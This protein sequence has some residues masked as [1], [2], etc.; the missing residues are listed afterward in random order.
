MQ[1]NPDV[2]RSRLL[3][4]A[5]K[6]GLPLSIATETA[7]P[8]VRVNSD[9]DEDPIIE[10]NDP[11]LGGATT[12][13][14]VLEHSCLSPFSLKVLC[15]SGIAKAPYVY[16]PFLRTAD[17]VAAH[18]EVDRR[19]VQAWKNRKNPMPWKPN[20]YSAPQIEYCATWSSATSR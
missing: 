3:R 15:A 13:E 20:Y 7:P 6:L 9:P 11:E 4:V 16:G 1:I 14:Q 2:A 19:T 17:D 12:L 5:E 18:F 8:S 10:L